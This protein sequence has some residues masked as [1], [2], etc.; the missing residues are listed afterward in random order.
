MT[1]SATASPYET[2]PVPK[3]RV[4]SGMMPTGTLHVGNY[5]GALSQWAEMQ[6]QY[7]NFFFIADLHALSIPESVRPDQL[8]ERIRENVGLYLATGL[9]PQRSVLFLQS[10]VPA[11]ASLAWIYNCVTPVSWL[12]RMTQYKVKAEQGSPSAGLL[13]YP[14]LQAADI[15]LYRA[16]YVPVGEDQRQHVELTRQIA[17]RFNH[18]FGETFVVPEPMIPPSGARIMG[19]D[20]PTAKMSKSTAEEREGHAL[21]LLDPPQT[22]KHAIMRAVTDSGSRIDRGDLSPGLDNLVTLYE[23]LSDST[24]EQVLDRFE[25]QGYGALKKELVEVAVQ[26]IGA[27]QRRYNEIRSDETYLDKVLAE[28]AERAADV[29]NDTLNRALR[30][31]GLA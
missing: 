16:N 6:D 20:E 23:V 19:L 22:I 4:L 31:V 18:M 7:E 26:R 1:A 28:G 15:V 17:A 25:G 24:R 30:F 10:H 2:R 9:D 27:V 29:A 14:V 11:H 13:T 8:R 21:R 12:E 3:P 5:V